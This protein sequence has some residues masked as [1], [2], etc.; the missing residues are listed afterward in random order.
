[1]EVKCP[2][3]AS[4]YDFTLR[5]PD[6]H[7]ACSDADRQQ[8]REEVPAGK[9]KEGTDSRGGFAAA[10]AKHEPGTH[11]RPGVYR[12]HKKSRSGKN[13]VVLSRDLQCTEIEKWGRSLPSELCVMT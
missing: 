2:E 11:D 7:A 6:D 5:E 12:V 9:T 13:W 8:H 4:E 1:V 10:A 3:G